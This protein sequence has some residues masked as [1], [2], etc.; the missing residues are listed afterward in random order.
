SRG[1]NAVDVRPGM[2]SFEER[3]LLDEDPDFW[4]AKSYDV[5]FCRNVLMYF[6]ADAAQ[7]VVA[8]LHRALA[9]GGYLFG[10]YAENL[11]GLSKDFH[12][13]HSHDT[14]YYQRRPPEAAP[15]AVAETPWYDSV[16]RSAERVER[17]T[18]RRAAPAPAPRQVSSG[19]HLAVGLDLLRRERYA[20]AAEH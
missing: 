14:F 3:N 2:V 7:A 10:G 4:G 16:R 19:S 11:R 17:L 13:C 20:E 12:L 9:D 15:P 5:I 6:T 8:R 1:D 18:E